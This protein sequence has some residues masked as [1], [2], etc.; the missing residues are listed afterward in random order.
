MANSFDIYDGVHD[1]SI[2]IDTH[3]HIYI[4]VS[5]DSNDLACQE[6]GVR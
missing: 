3:S 4:C 6:S 1:F 5:C 2:S